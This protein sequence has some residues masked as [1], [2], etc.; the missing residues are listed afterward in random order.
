VS[1]MTVASSW[2][3]SSRSTCDCRSIWRKRLRRSARFRLLRLFVCVPLVVSQSKTLRNIRSSS[4]PKV[5]T[6][7][8]PG[9]RKRTQLR[10]HRAKSPCRSPAKH[11]SGFRRCPIATSHSLVFQSQTTEKS[12]DHWPLSLPLANQQLRNTWDFRREIPK[13]KVNTE[14][15]FFLNYQRMQPAPWWNTGEGLVEA[16]PSK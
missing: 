10:Q 9:C 13:L 6:L 11:S 14:V 12:L 16:I 1:T 15:I 2:R 5:E 8:H 3:G 7:N 4:T